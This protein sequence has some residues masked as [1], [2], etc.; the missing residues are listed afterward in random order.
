MKK[1]GSYYFG[2]LK[3][4]VDILREQITGLNHITTQQHIV[5]GVIPLSYQV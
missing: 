3:T 1:T 2:D 5:G 4:Q